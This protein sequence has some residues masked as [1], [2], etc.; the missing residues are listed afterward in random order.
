MTASTL[1]LPLLLGAGVQQPGP[2]NAAP[3]NAPHGV[4][5]TDAAHRAVG[6]WVGDWK[7]VD[8]ASS[9][10]VARSRIEWIL[11][12]CAIRESYAQTVG[13]GGQN[14]DYR[15][16][17]QTALDV[18]RGQWRQFYVDSAGNTSD[19]TGGLRDGKLVMRAEK[20]GGTNRMTIE[21]LPDGNVR[22]RGE[23]SMDGGRTWTPGYD[24][25]YVREP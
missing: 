23:R 20:N 5:C 16:S 17:S 10:P 12:G 11:G 25:T 14:L 3:A 6:F 1:L 9:T 21:A 2:P 24:F 15:G 19:F 4:D 22:Q 8:T 7:V 18:A 13:P